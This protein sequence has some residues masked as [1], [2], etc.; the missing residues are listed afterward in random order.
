MIQHVTYLYQFNLQFAQ[1]LVKDLSAEQM[2]GQPN[3]VINHPAWSLGHLTVSADHLGTFLGLDSVLAEGW[4]K[5]FATGGIPSGDVS[6][7][8]SKDELLAA[9]TA[10]HERNTEAVRNADLAR[11]TEPHPDEGSRK[12][13]P[14]VGDMVVFLMTSHE[15][16]HLGQVA[17]W[18]RAMELGPAR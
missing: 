16:D 13:F 3:G 10:Q 9:L 5:P 18:R 15:M 1:T 7:Y 17:A 2:V 11:F 4:D 14:T 6:A 8:P 12:Y